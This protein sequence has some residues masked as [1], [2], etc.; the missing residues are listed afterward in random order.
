MLIEE[1]KDIVY[2]TYSADFIKNIKTKFIKEKTNNT[3]L[4]IILSKILLV[5]I[6]NYILENDPNSNREIY[7]IKREYEEYIKDNI[8][9]LQEI[10][11]RTSFE[12]FNF[13]NLDDFYLEGLLALL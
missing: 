1:N 2:F 13:K 10:N 11:L 4:N 12:E 9:N 6:N 7:N 5:L 8:N 3:L